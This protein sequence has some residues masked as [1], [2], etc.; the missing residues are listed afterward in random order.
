MLAAGSKPH[1]AALGK[2]L[3]Q[4]IFDRTHEDRLNKSA[5]P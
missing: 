1:I 3:S 2:P 5:L 4:P